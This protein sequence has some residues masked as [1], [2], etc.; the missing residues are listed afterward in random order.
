MNAVLK[1]EKLETIFDHHVTKEELIDLFEEEESFDD[2][3]F[4]LGQNSA[5]A[6]LYFLYHLRNDEKTAVS[7]LNKISDVS[8]RQS[9]SFSC[10]A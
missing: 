2:Y 4:S 7:F 8:Y 3:C 10:C 9:I 5:Y 1:P 6:H